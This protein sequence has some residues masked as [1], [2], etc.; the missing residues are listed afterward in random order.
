M[1]HEELT[2]KII[3]AAIAVHKVIGPGL[4]EQSYQAAIAMEFTELGLQFQRE[5][6]LAVTYKGATV[7]HHVP[8][9]IVESAVVVELASVART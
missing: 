5:P 4:K 8:D 2:D 1:L 7:G 6:V 9:F 3:G